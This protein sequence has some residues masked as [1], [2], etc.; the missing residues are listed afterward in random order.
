MPE[1][2]TATFGFGLN[3]VAPPRTPEPAAGGSA[4]SSDEVLGI[5]QSS[6]PSAASDSADGT[7]LAHSGNTTRY[8]SYFG[9]ILVGYGAYFRAA[10]RGVRRR[11][12][13]QR[14]GRF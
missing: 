13:E 12:D 5:T 8:L 14:P 4:G 10:D 7:A 6:Q 2:P 9:L 3:P 11:D 1:G